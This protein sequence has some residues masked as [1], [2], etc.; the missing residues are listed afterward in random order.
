MTIL[1][2]NKNILYQLLCIFLLELYN[3]SFLSSEIIIKKHKALRRQYQQYRD[4]KEIYI[5][6]K[7]QWNIYIIFDIQT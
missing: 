6:R 5:Y 2:N 3:S 1:K 7:D 4:K